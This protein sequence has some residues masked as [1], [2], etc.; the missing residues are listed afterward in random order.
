M[1]Q[2]ISVIVDQTLE[3]KAHLHLCYNKGSSYIPLKN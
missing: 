1:K 3:L 2:E